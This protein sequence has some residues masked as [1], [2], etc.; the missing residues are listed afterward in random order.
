MKNARH[1]GRLR[2]RAAAL[3]NKHFPHWEVRPEDIQPAT[4]RWRTDW[5]LDVYRWEL[6]SQTKT[7]QPV[8]CGCW[9][10]LTE[11]V[12]EATKYGCYMTADREICAGRPTRK[13]SK[14]E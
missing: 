11:F 6:Y 13:D 5:R 7:G 14:H 3:L 4:G 9:E 2:I 1:V 10:T 12:R 8:V